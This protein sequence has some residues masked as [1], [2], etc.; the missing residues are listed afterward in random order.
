MVRLRIKYEKV[1]AIRYASHRDTMRLFRRALAAGDV[2]V[3]YSQGF[4]PHPRLSFGPSLRTGWE[5]LGEYLDVLLDEPVPD[6]MDRCNRGLP[7]GLHIL[8]T[9]VVEPSV[10]KLSMDV[11]AARYSV[12]IDDCAGNE[13]QERDT[14]AGPRTGRPDKAARPDRKRR[15]ELE[16]AIRKQHFFETGEGPSPAVLELEIFTKAG[17]IDIEYLTTMH[18]GKCVLP[19]E[20]LEPLGQDPG[21][22]A[23]PIKVIRRALYVERQG[24]FVLPVSKGAVQGKP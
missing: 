24:S 8:E 9:A 1:G 18:Q 13:K 7:D 12:F 19:H 23:I 3:C 20:L 22:L 5:G 14:F 10:P 4:N 17:G 21:A 2:P 16:A 6:F 15:P 11:R